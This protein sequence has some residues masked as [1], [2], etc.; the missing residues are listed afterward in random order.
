VVEDDRQRAYRL[1]REG[2][3]QKARRLCEKIL[4]KTRND[5]IVLGLLGAIQFQ[6]KEFEKSATT[7]EKA[8][9]ADPNN[10]DA[11]NN[12]GVALNQLERY[13]AAVD[14]LGRAAELGPNS[15][16]HH[17]N[18]GV[19]LKNAGRAS[20][21]LEAFRRAEEI[22]P[23]SAEAVNQQGMVLRA[24]G[25]SD[26]AVECYRRSLWLRPH[27]AE[28]YRL[29]A[30]VKTFVERDDD[31]RTMER[32]LADPGTR[33][34][35][36]MRLCFALGKAY[37]DIKDFDAAFRCFE[38]G[39]RLRREGLRYDVGED[40]TKAQRIADVF[41]ADL[42]D[43][44][45]Q[46]GDPSEVP[47]F[48][49][50]MPRSGTTLVEQILASHSQVF[51][52]GE[53]NDLERLAEGVR[54]G[55]GGRFPEN[56]RQLKP[57]AVRALGESYVAGLRSRAPGQA[58]ITDKMPLNFFYVGLIHLMVPS[59]RIVH[60]LRDPVDTCLS[61]YLQ[62]FGGRQPFAWDLTELGRYYRTYR[63]LM[64]H[65]DAVLPGR[66]L[67]V[68]YEDLVA[69]TEAESRRLIRHCG[70][71]WED[72][73]LA[74]QRTNRPVLTASATQVRRGIYTSSVARWRRYERHLGPLIEA[75]G[76]VA[77]TD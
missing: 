29:L 17:H 15:A 25:R 43:R 36:V 53:L 57:G 39:N 52:A 72:G 73:C 28:T 70:L 48:V 19:A 30:N 4:R 10:L 74:F 20:A 67:E 9:A 32:L 59:A 26:E 42:F 65:W 22:D 18:L 2:R 16:E 33:P 11:I 34:G 64:D 58:R 38:R 3:A 63:A 60:C 1:F 35:D 46:R 12:L 55:V 14:V 76:P 61:C 68:R 27:Q 13:A 54:P 75:L 6:A 69:D 45:R 71:E 44:H 21:A 40:E 24:L 50:G 31:I 62:F 66:V 56:I 47:I 49:L 51:A 8:V 5:S 37:E 77:A 41:G 23:R 7:L